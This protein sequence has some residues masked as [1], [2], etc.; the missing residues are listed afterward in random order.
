MDSVDERIKLKASLGIG[1][2]VAKMLELSLI[3]RRAERLERRLQQREE[4]NSGF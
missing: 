4:A 1:E 2:Q 3:A